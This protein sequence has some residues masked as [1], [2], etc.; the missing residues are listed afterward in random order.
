[1]SHL[2]LLLLLL[3]C[4]EQSLSKTAITNYATVELV[5]N[6]PLNTLVIQLT[7]SFN[8]TRTSKF[9]LLNMIGFESNMFSIVN[10]SIYTVD[11]IDREEFL[12]EKYCLDGLYCK[13]ELHVLVDGG[14]AYWVI[15]V[16]IVE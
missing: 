5:E 14:Q 12:R 1:M 8:Q 7:T 15:P 3:S 13:I 16:H 2:W 4:I 9:V 10:G 6:S 11:Y